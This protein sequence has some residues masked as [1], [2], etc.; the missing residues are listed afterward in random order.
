MAAVI[1]VVELGRAARS[2]ANVKVRQPLPAVLVYTAQP[3]RMRGREPPRRTR[4]STSSTSRTSRRFAMLGEVVTYEHPAEPAGARPK[5]GKQL[6]AIRQALAAADSGHGR[7]PVGAERS[8]ELT[9][10][11][12]E[13]FRLDPEVLVD[14]N[15]R[16]ATPPRR[17]RTDRRAR[18][19]V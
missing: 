10:P 15:K 2:E 13:A 7:G 16:E 4:C 11:N 18:H 19:R 5:Y 14:L 8:V 9:L 6:G 17:A 1:E 12:G 3:A